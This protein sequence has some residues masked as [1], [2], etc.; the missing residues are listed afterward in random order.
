MEAYF[1]NDNVG[2]DAEEEEVRTNETAGGHASNEKQSGTPFP[3]RLYDILEAESPLIISWTDEGKAFRI[4][5][6]QAFQSTVLLK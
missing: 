2:D 3:K 5:D 1:P 6:V 4:V